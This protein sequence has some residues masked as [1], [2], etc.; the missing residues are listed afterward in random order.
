MLNSLFPLQISS[1]ASILVKNFILHILIAISL[2]SVSS[3]FAATVVEDLDNLQPPSDF[4]STLTNNCR[5]NPSLRYCNSTPF[6]LLKIFKST[7][8]ASHLCKLSRNP[9]CVESFPKIDLGSQPTI[10]PLYLSF[11]FFWEYCPLT[12][13]SID[14]SNTSLQ[15]DFQLMYF[16]AHKFSLLI[17]A[18]ITS[19]EIS[20][21]RS[22]HLSKTSSSS[23]CPTTVSPSAG[24]PKRA[25]SSVLSLRV[26]FTLVFS[27][28]MGS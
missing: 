4:N 15:G 17:S 22:S 11:S 18:S 1:M 2:I 10:A 8:V 20:L 5:N 16:P 7:I 23:T 9:N 12:V 14:F 6:N 21:W 19:L 24:S 13:V 27:P 25:F 28:I 3:T 26:L